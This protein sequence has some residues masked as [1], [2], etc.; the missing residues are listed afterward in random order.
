MFVTT[1][2]RVLVFPRMPSGISTQYGVDDYCPDVYDRL[3]RQ[4]K[5]ILCVATDDN[6][7][8]LSLDD[9]ASDS[10]GGFVMINADE[11]S[12]SSVIGALMSGDFYASTG[13]YIYSIVKDGDQVTVKTS[14][15]TKIVLRYSH[16]IVRAIHDSSGNMT[17]ATF[18]LPSPDMD[19][20][21]IVH[22]KDGAKAYSQYYYN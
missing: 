14:S 11:L 18:T 5:R 1:I 15:A 21:I 17:E 12:Y 13:A 10:F 22:A 7:N 8:R 6:H 2:L 20:R 3:L 9:P 19:F 16:R 4:G